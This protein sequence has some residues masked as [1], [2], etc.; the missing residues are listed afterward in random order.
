[1]RW[2]AQAKKGMGIPKGF[3]SLPTCEISPTSTPHPACTGPVSAARAGSLCSPGQPRVACRA[4]GGLVPQLWAHVANNCW[5]WLC[6]VPGVVCSTI[7]CFWGQ[8]TSSLSKT[9]TRRWAEHWSWE[10]GWIQP[11]FPG[12][13]HYPPT[14]LS[15]QLQEVH[16]GVSSEDLHQRLDKVW[17][18]LIPIGHTA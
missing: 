8:R 7:S 4:Q 17:A 5:P 11:L 14:H 18:L 10:K 2:K 1:M 13:P 6:P 3:S 12:H 9:M 15:H 16:L